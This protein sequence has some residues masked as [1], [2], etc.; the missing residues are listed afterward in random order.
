MQG[1]ESAAE[2]R[3]EL[4]LKLLQLDCCKRGGVALHDAANRCK[5]GKLI[6]IVLRIPEN[7]SST[8]PKISHIYIERGE[9]LEE[10]LRFLLTSLKT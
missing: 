3:I 5:K 10:P 4:L 1:R 7:R 2:L 8:T 9:I 6:T